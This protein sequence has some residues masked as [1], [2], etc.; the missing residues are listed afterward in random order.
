MKN[1]DFKYGHGH[2]TVSLNEKDVLA[3]LHGTETPPIR[4]IRS[5][6]PL[7]V[8]L[9]AGEPERGTRWRWWSAT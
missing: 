2:V 4:D 8:R 6:I 5:A 3:E 7:T 1:Y 9:C